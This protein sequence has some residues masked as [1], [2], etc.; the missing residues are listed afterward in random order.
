MR[1]I[2]SAQA[3]GM[4]RK[5]EEKR[6]ICVFGGGVSRGNERRRREGTNAAGDEDFGLSGVE[7]LALPLKGDGPDCCCEAQ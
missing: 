1:Q 2:Q 6:S 5:K 7:Q 3:C 4:R